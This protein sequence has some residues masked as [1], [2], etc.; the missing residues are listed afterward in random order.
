MLAS[1]RRALG[2][3]R[4]KGHRLAEHFDTRLSL[5]RMLTQVPAILPPTILPLIQSQHVAGYVMQPRTIGQLLLDVGQNSVNRGLAVYPP[6]FAGANSR[7]ST[8]L[9][10]HGFW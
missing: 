7:V 6:R 1:Y 9:S 2:W 5:V 8:S 3:S 4:R 10:S